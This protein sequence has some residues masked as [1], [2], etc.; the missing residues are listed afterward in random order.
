MKRNR[1]LPFWMALLLLL[2]LAGCA[3]KDKEE[4]SS[5]LP[6]ESQPQEYPVSI[7]DETISAQPAKVISLSPALTEICFDMGYG[8]QLSGVSDYCSWPQQVQN[9]PSSRI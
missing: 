6:E 1:I 7:G 3:G 2:S 9:L 8:T 5:S 4:S